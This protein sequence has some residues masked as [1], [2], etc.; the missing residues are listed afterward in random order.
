MHLQARCTP[1]WP[2]T[3]R[4]DAPLQFKLTLQLPSH[5]RNGD[6]LTLTKLLNRNH[7]VASVTIPATLRVTPHNGLCERLRFSFIAPVSMMRN[8]VVPC[9]SGSGTLFAP[10]QNGWHSFQR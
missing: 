5:L 4:A 6:T 8:A 3:G 2:T 7:A 1:A 10:S 9:V